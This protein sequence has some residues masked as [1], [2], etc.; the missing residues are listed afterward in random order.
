VVPKNW[1]N[2]E[3]DRMTKEVI[4]NEETKDY[5]PE[6]KGKVKLKSLRNENARWRNSPARIVFSSRR[7]NV[8][9]CGHQSKLPRMN[10]PRSQCR[11]LRIRRD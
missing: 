10:A 11:L 7:E 5:S 2:F 6:F 1:F 3:M 4:Q 8:E 9:Y